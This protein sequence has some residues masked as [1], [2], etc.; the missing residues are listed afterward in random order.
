MCVLDISSHSTIIC[1]EHSET[2]S[3][4]ELT[5]SRT[6]GTLVRDPCNWV[7]LLFCIRCR[8]V[9]SE[10]MK[11]FQLVLVQSYWT[12]HTVYLFR[13]H[14]VRQWKRYGIM[15][16]TSRNFCVV[17]SRYMHTRCLGSRNVVLLYIALYRDVSG[18]LPTAASYARGCAR[19]GVVYRAARSTAWYLRC[20][21]I[22]PAQYVMNRHMLTG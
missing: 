20:R 17:P 8:F 3:R 13:V 16:P 21:A 14:V 22:I 7:F 10:Y 2:C 5:A 19:I 9:Y 6:T 15:V 18:L 4:S 1:Q 11:G 12:C